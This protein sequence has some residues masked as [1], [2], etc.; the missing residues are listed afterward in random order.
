MGR[1][2]ITTKRTGPKSKDVQEMLQVM[3]NHQE[4]Q[5]SYYPGLHNMS[6]SFLTLVTYSIDQFYAVV[7]YFKKLS[8]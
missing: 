1:V 7:F 4:G 5:D 8:F 6:N 3:G 2:D